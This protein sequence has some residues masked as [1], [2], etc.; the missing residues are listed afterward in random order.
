MVLLEISASF[1]TTRT[2][3]LISHETC[4][5]SGRLYGN[6]LRFEISIR[7]RSEI[8]IRLWIEKAGYSMRL[9]EATLSTGL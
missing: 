4:K 8:R 5:D 7:L 3:A 9:A 6:C 2:E 1:K